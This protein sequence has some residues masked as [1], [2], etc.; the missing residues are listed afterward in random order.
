M[1]SGFGEAIKFFAQLGTV[2]GELSHSKKPEPLDC[3]WFG[4]AI[5]HLLRIAINLRILAELIGNK[6][7]RLINRA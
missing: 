6:F 5:K 1:A 3:L 7:T 4:E 2:S